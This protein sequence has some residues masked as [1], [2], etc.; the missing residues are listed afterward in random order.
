MDDYLN[1]PKIS[2]VM[3]VHNGEG[4]ISETLQSILNQSFRDFEL[5]ILD[6]GS[7]DDTAKII[8]NYKTKDSRIVYHKNPTKRGLSFSRNKVI[9]EARASLIAVTDS[10]DV[11]HPDRF[12]IQ[13]EFLKSHGDISIVGS[14][15]TLINQ[16]NIAFEQ[17]K[18]PENNDE[19]IQGLK[20]S[21]AV[22]NPTCMFYKEVFTAIDGYDA[23]LTICEDWDFFLRA[24]RQQYKF[25][26]LNTPLIYYRIHRNNISKNK[27]EHTIVYSMY[28]VGKIS[29]EEAGF[30]ID[31]LV[32]KHPELKKQVVQKIIQFY[33]FWI[34]TYFKIGYK[35]LSKELFQ[36]ANS[37]FF[38][39]F[40]IKDKIKFTG[41]YI[42][43]NLVY[44]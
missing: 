7:T 16:D 23:N 1:Y 11:N 3:I 20:N 12:K 5:V 29:K 37:K 41:V 28:S 10:D 18:Y 40:P 44:R 36:F 14:A 34:E 8:S 13:Y 31:N 15:L 22:A 19:I 6:D 39:L 38:K 25:H 24:A 42:K 21:C 32:Y 9:T 17:W 43:L 30:D 4:F 2:A 26:N 33:V 35:E 27:L